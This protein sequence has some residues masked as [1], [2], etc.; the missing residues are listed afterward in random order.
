MEM[1]TNASIEGC[2]ANVGK[3]IYIR[4]LC[5]HIDNKRTTEQ[6]NRTIE[7]I[8]AA[9]NN[10]W[11]NVMS[12]SNDKGIYEKYFKRIFDIAC[13]FT[14]LFFFWWL[15]IIIAV[16]VRIKLGSPVIFKQPRPGKS[17]K[18]FYICKFRT[19]T[20]AKDK[21][22]NLLPDEKRLTHFGAWLRS[23]SLDELPEVWLI[24]TGRMGCVGPRPLLIRDM[25]F[26]SEE[27]R[28]RHSVRPGLTG[29]A[30]ISG[31]NDIDWNDKLNLD[32][33]YVNYIT[34]WSDVKIILLTVLNVFKR[35][36]ITE[37]NKATAADYGDYLLK[38]N[39]VSKEEYDECQKKAEKIIDKLS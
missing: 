6:K 1:R 19:M 10:E 33:E 16:M 12:F 21:E 3:Y 22:G 14:F 17:E 24:L 26:M 9:L 8:K 27:H 36:G 23:T 4:G 7:I 37:C 34:F 13:S 29:L 28:K 32:L 15:Y 11:R 20:D 25:V 5:L 30:Q 31:R 18:I 35:E 38:K 2:A 39:D